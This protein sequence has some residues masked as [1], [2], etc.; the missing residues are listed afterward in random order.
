[1]Y[2]NDAPVLELSSTDKTLFKEVIDGTLF[3][4]VKFF[5]SQDEVNHIMGYVFHKS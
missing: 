2:I 5:S 4:E 3:K 1:M